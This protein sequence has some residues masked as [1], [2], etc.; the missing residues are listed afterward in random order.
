M[1]HREVDP[2][3]RGT[4]QPSAGVVSESSPNPRN[5]RLR[6]AVQVSAEVDLELGV[7]EA[8]VGQGSVAREQGG[9]QAAEVVLLSIR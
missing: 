8:L 1:R 3:D 6:A 7:S 5:L 9:S 2:S 4:R